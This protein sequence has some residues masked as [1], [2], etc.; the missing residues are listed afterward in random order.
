MV[1]EIDLSKPLSDD[2]IAYLKATRPLGT[3]ERLIE[4]ANEAGAAAES[5]EESDEFDPSKHKVSEVKEYLL[6]ASEEETQRVLQAE[7]D[8][9][10]RPTILTED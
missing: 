9:Q 3:V 10:A 2:D 8:G 6:T 1:R 7:R 4:V 5:E